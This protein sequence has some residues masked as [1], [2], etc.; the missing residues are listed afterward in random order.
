MKKLLAMLP[1]PAALLLRWIASAHPLWVERF[2]STGLYP[3]IARP[4]SRLTA[5]VPFSLLEPLLAILLLLVLYSLFK[6]RVFRV[7]ALLGLVAAVFLGG[8]SL[9]YYRLPLETTLDLPVALSTP[10]E[11]AALADALIDDVNARHVPLDGI[12]LAEATGALNAAAESWPIPHGDYGSPKTALMSP[13]MS[14]LL[15]EGI[16]S[17][18]TLE[19]LVNGGAPAVSRPFVACH[20]AAHVRGF[21]R[22]EDA[23]LIAYLACEA[24]SDPAYRY[25]GAFS[26]LLYT[27][28]A[29]RSADPDAYLACRARISEDVLRDI[30][31]HADYWNAFRETKAATVGTQMNNTYLKTVGGGQQSARSYGRVVDL[32][33]ALK[34]KK[35]M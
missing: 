1:L 9:N 34:R 31:A 25:S 17:P 23:N 14:E 21:A 8:W 15:I 28:D 32:L 13:L 29:L 6:K 12:S 22:E 26:A 7:F 27:L 10:E 24:S 19:A 2:F 35:G 5:L 16:T 3:A 30:A 20:E 18:F 4:V 11:L 33:L